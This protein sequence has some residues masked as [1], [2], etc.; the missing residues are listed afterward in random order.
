M[1]SKTCLLKGLTGGQIL[2]KNFYYSVPNNILDEVIVHGEQRFKLMKEFRF[3]ELLSPK[4]FHA[5]EK[6][7]N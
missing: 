2:A 6:N 7:T 1:K 5:Y 4:L 3:V